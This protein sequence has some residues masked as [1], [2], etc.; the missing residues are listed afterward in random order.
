MACG[1]FR[2]ADTPIRRRDDILRDPAGPAPA[3]TDHP[4]RLVE[5]YEAELRQAG[6]PVEFARRAAAT[7]PEGIWHPGLDELFAAGV[8]TDLEATPAHLI[9]IYS[10]P[11]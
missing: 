10:A 9:E 11:H 3:P 6:L 7:P 5:A 4:E 2:V 8:I 1:E